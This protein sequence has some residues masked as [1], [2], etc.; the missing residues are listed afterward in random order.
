MINITKLE[1]KFNSFNKFN[2]VLASFFFS[3]MTLCV[4]N[5][6]KRIPIY[7]LVLFRSL[8]SL[9]F[10]LSI[11]KLKNIN[12]WGKNKPLLI[13]RGV[14]GTLALVCIFYA[15]RNMPL[16]ISTII[17]Y[18]YPIFISIFAGIFINEKITK[19]II[20]ALIIGWIG[21][22]VI[23][24]P[25][26]LSNINVE[27]KNSSILIA[28]LGAIC[29]A[30]AYVTVKKLSFTEDI[31]VIIEYFP[32]VSLITLL[33]IVLINWVT[34]NWDELVWIIGIGLFTQLGQTFLT[35]GLK[36][37]PAF[38]ASTINYLQVL[39]GSIWGIL[40]FS[41]IIN[42]NFLVG[43]LLVLLGTIISTT[44]SQKKT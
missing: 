12:P 6:D 37:F 4:K 10:T 19:N 13:L 25:I 36:N 40:F 16:S 38:E 14:L 39:F 41:E 8:L 31:Y 43:T 22:L 44:K 42:I 7:E 26:Q 32:L 27:I 11:I 21:I 15:I 24:N 35:I 18:T 29:T 20:I 23:L 17:Q 9:I 28:F 33:P 30:L 5:I 34:P 2:L 3:L 1:K